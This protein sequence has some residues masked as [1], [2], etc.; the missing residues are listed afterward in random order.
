MAFPGF[1]SSG[2]LAG[3][4]DGFAMPAVFTDFTS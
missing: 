1:V 4:F 3:A 2:S